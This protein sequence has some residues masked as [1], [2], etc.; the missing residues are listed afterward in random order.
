MFADIFSSPAYLA[1]IFR[2]LFHLQPEEDFCR[3]DNKNI[4][5]AL[6][7]KTMIGGLL[8]LRKNGFLSLTCETPSVGSG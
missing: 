6:E 5:Y 2:E 3:D 7:T 8:Y 1:M 4:S